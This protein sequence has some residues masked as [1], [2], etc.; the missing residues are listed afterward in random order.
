M[1]KVISNFSSNFKLLAIVLTLLSLTITISSSSSSSLLS[2]SLSL[3]QVFVIGAND[4]ESSCLPGTI[5]ITHCSS[6][7]ASTSYICPD[8]DSALEYIINA[9]QYGNISVAHVCL[10][11]GYFTLT[12]P[13]YLNVSITL[14]GVINQSIIQCDYDSNNTIATSEDEL[15]FTLSFSRVSFVRFD[16]VQFKSCPQPLR[17]T[18]AEDVMIS[19][20]RFERF[21]EGVF[22]I[23][24]SNNI[25]IVNSSFVNNYGTGTVLIPFRGNTGAVAI[26]YNNAEP[27]AVD[28]LVS[29]DHCVFVNNSADVSA[30]SMVTSNNVIAAGVFTGRGG[31]LGLFIRYSFRSVSALISDS[32]FRNNYAESFAGAMYVVLSGD[33]T[34]HNVTVQDCLFVTNRANR[35]AGGV[36]FVFFSNGL[37]S[38]PLT[39][40]AFNCKFIGN[41]ADTGGGIYI[42]PEYT[43]GGEGNIVFI[44]NCTFAE[45]EATLFG[46][47][48]AT[49]IYSLFQTRHLLPLHHIINW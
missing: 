9:A 34:Q 25:T 13:Q 27:T 18:L 31:S 19:N 2:S 11:S 14:T 47:A 41:S 48:I 4:L 35:G 38:R 32:E 28:P 15:Q 39:A 29:V 10:P 26:G 45:N 5:N 30:E 37:R 49:A 44:E 7:V 43:I 20:S 22:D 42:F 3:V 36:I 12:S 46:G 8:L 16:G 33:T 21:S 1:C 23:F 17:I 24:N 40:T 6:H